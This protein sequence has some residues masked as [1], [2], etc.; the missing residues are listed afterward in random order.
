MVKDAAIA[1]TVVFILAVVLV[2]A[3]DYVKKKRRK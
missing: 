2:T 3:V 1:V